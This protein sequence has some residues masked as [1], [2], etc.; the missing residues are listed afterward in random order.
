M[1]PTINGLPVE[2]LI[3]DDTPA[4]LK[5]LTSILNAKGYMVRAA[6]SG[7]L[8]LRSI[9]MKKPD[10]ILLD[11]RMPDIDGYEVCSRLKN[12]ENTRHIP[13]IFISAIDAV[14]DKIKAFNVGGED[15]ITKP[16]EPDEVLARVAVHA[17]LYSARKS[18]HDQN[19]L[20]Q[21]LLKK[22]KEH[23]C[24]LIQQSKM[25]AMGEM[26]G[27]IAHQW[28]QP[29]NSLGLNIQDVYVT[30]TLGELNSDYM[31]KFKTS[32]MSIIQNMSKTIDD[33]RNFYRPTKEKNDFFLE[34]AVDETLNIIN[35]QLKN[36]HIEVNFTQEGR[37]LV[38]GYQNELEQAILIVI[39]NAQDALIDNKIKNPKIDI[40]VQVDNNG[41]VRLS[42]QDNAGGISNEIVD[43]IFE[44]YFTT[45]EKGKGT[46][47]GLYMAKE[48]VERHSNG[49][50]IVENSNGGANFII[51][52]P[53]VC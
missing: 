11:I 20:L 22:E 39:S 31:N 18:L 51:T 12:D 26:I 13:I 37:H 17:E 52:I 8:A 50:I 4:N 49:K 10:L 33:F 21:E 5:L 19:I 3:V 29:L 47:I 45:K 7:E 24:M 27:V 48:I 34:S 23:K 43:R 32:N 42:I 36:H 30:H 1:A 9:E 15:Y 44:P 40:Y 53:L 14:S 41:M 38:N 28:K 6:P 25:A 46:G 16:F 2:I 35:P